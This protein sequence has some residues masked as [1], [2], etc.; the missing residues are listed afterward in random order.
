MIL[1]M[2]NV[3]L[4]LLGCNYLKCIHMHA[5]L[6]CFY[7]RCTNVIICTH[8]CEIDLRVSEVNNACL[9]PE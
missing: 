4:M 8:V 7:K 5:S 9:D 3:K 6:L 1:L 2:K